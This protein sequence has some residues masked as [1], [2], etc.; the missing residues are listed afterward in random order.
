[1][2]NITLSLAS[3]LFVTFGAVSQT[4]TPSENPIQEEFSALIENSNSYKNYKVIDFGEISQLQKNTNAH[5]ESLNQEIAATKKMVET[6][7]K[8]ISGLKTELDNTQTSLE[9]VTA[10][11]NS[12]EFLGMPLSKTAYNLVMWS[13]IGFLVIGLALLFISFRKSH[14]LTKEAQHKLDET[15]KEFEAFRIKS[16]EK[17]QRLGRLLQDEKNKLM[18]LSKS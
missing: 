12:I 6:Q 4:T 1:M 14:I 16:L 10:E 5:I 7:E 2:K 8:S 11:K 17:E 9:E 3:L 13:I 18:K 15:E